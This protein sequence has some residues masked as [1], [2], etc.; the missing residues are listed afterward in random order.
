MMKKLSRS[1]VAL[2]LVP[3]TLTDYPAW[4]GKTVTHTDNQGHVTLS[5]SAVGEVRLS[6]SYLSY[7]K[8]IKAPGGRF[9]IRVPAL[10]L[11][12]LIP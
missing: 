4:V 1:S 12:S 5:V 2:S 9:E 10:R 11:P 7:N 3:I 8:T 6:L